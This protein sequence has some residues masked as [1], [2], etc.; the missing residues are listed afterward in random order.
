[1]TSPAAIFGSLADFKLVKTRSVVQFI[2]EVPI[3]QADVALATLGGIPLP[4]VE[5]P[6]ALARLN[7]EPE[8]R[9][10]FTAERTAH[11]NQVKEVVPNNVPSGRDASK[12]PAIVSEPGANPE[13]S[14]SIGSVPSKVPEWKDPDP[15]KIEKITAPSEVHR[16]A[17]LKSPS[18]SLSA[19]E[20]YRQDSPMGQALKRACILCDDGRFQMWASTRNWGEAFTTI[21]EW[22]R[23]KLVIKSRSEIGVDKA[24]YERFL[25]LET[26]YQKETGLLPEERG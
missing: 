18:K 6:V 15:P 25:A 12:P 8:Q 24:A 14:F 5:R 26:Q 16:E 20:Q 2:V 1:M 13:V 17:A 23:T 3:E 21:D 22:M 19:K 4:G 10:S 11:L 9:V 7:A